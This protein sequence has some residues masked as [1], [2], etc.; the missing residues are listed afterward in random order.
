VTD[1]GS[2]LT[3]RFEGTERRGEAVGRR[4]TSGH[5][6]GGVDVERVVSSDGRAARI[7]PLARPGWGRAGIAYGPWAPRPGLTFSVHL[8]NGHNAAQEHPP[9]RRSRLVG[10]WV[11]GSGTD[12]WW[13]RLLPL[14]R[15]TARE[16]RRHRL[17]RYLLLDRGHDPDRRSPV[18]LALGW[19]DRER[20]G[21]VDD[22]YGVVTV[23]GAGDH[24]GVLRITGAAG[25]AV[26]RERLGELP[27]QLLAITRETGVVVYAAVGVDDGTPPR[28]QPVGLVA[29]A[30]PGRRWAGVHQR[31]M[32][33]IGFSPDTRVYEAHVAVVAQWGRWWTAA[34]AADDLTGEGD[35]AGSTSATGQPW[36]TAGG[37]LRRSARGLVAGPP[38]TVR[39]DTPGPVGPDIPPSAGRL[40]D[41]GAETGDRGGSGAL[42]G[43]GVIDAGVPVGLVRVVVT[44]GPDGEAALHWR[45][46]G[47][48]DCWRLRLGPAGCSIEKWQGGTVVRRWPLADRAAGA[49]ID[50]VV[51]DDGEEIRVL[52]DGRPALDA[53]IVDTAH[54]EATSVG[55]GVEGHGS[56]VRD[57]EA[58]A[59][60]LDVPA[61]VRTVPCR[62]SPGKVE[63]WT[64]TFTA[65]E[66]DLAGRPG[67]LGPG[68]RCGPWER[69]LGTDRFLLR[70]G[71][72]EVDAS[73]G[74]PSRGRTLYTVPWDRPAFADLAVT[75]RP[76]GARRGHG[77]RGRAGVVL[78]QDQASYVVVNTWLDDD[79]AGSSI[80][81]FPHLG[82]FED[83]FDAVWVNVG[84][85]VRWGVPFELRVVCDGESLLLLVDSAAVL[86]R[87]FADIDPRHPRLAVARVGLA[88]NWE[89]GTDTGTTFT[90]LVARHP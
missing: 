55:V 43:P 67:P 13:R 30:L 45:H 25:P 22:Q 7:G 59:R 74:A 35:L 26:V 57:L 38:G 80:S 9:R 60:S 73:L 71:G 28:L 23:A 48:G 31:L 41:D 51:L 56:A 10:R 11:L 24:S 75:M 85:R 1:V 78:W 61:E 20:A 62:I 63:A 84:E 49:E 83:V 40:A 81:V 46:R 65:P 3:D 29:R 32:G 33:E 89:W 14:V 47:V 77:H 42:R 76:P 5:R 19:F 86:Y 8:L 21:D 52:L 53:P 82:G 2:P 64:E 70:R 88:V 90:R 17:R 18:N 12:A 72:L 15:H 4:T 44:L 68:G 58:H 87:R 50:A 54:A 66:G 69:T 16:T 6:R 36:R 27:L 39:L 79:F 37:S 34:V